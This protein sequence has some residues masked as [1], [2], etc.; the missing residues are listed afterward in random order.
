MPTWRRPPSKTSPPGDLQ[1]VRWRPSEGEPAQREVTTWSRKERCKGIIE[2]THI[3]R[4]GAFGR[5]LVA[6][7]DGDGVRLRGCADHYLADAAPHSVT[8]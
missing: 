7:W 2:Y 3:N 1:V 5:V 6:E 4:G 8:V